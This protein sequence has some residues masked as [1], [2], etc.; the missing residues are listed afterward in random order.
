M[1]AMVDDNNDDETDSLYVVGPDEDAVMA[2]G[3][4]CK[5]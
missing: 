3:A 5:R 4:G 1:T 2:R